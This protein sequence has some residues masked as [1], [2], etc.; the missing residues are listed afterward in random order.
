MRAKVQADWFKP[1]RPEE[2]NFNYTEANAWQYNFFVPQDVNTMIDW[3]GG[4]EPFDEFL[5][6]LFTVSSET[7]GRHQA[8]ITGLIGQ[9]AH[10]NEPS[11]HMAYLYNYAGK[12]WKTQHRVREILHTMYHNQPDGLSGNEDCG[13][14]SSWYVLSAMGFY[15]VTPGSVDYI[16]GAPLFDEVKLNLEN[17]ES[18]VIKA[19]NQS[20]EN[21]YVKSVEMNGKP[22]RKAF[23]K[24]QDMMNGGSLEFTMSENPVKDWYTEFPVQRI[25]E[26]QIVPVP[27][28]KKG[29]N[30]F[31]DKASI[32]LGCADNESEIFYTLGESI[33]KK[34]FKKYTRAIKLE[35]TTTIHFYAQKEDKKSATLKT[36]F[37]QVP[38]NISIKL[39][40]TYAN[41]YAASGDHALIDG[42][43]GG[44]NFKTGTWQ[45]YQGQ[46]VV[47]TIDLSEKQKVN[48]LTVGFLQD[49]KSW[50]VYPEWVEILVSDDGER[51]VSI[52]KITNE[53]SQ[54]KMGAMVQRFAFDV[55]K[56][57]RFIKMIAKN[58][59]VLPEWH[60]GAGGKPWIFTDEMEIE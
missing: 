52:R 1:F 21:Q 51:F 48:K 54:K 6:E 45:G 40:A 26:E 34:S 19:S 57:V 10:G 49:S 29:N 23:I 38:A 18:F 42:L 32:E 2:V 24:H 39:D 25:T 16:L 60:L 14:M 11:H 35:K 8:D 41:Q 56:E 9:Y 33:K 44:D 5:T 36:T 43:K 27:Y 17:G 30:T 37:H 50:I 31:V 46:D 59:G 3:M 20:E 55:D 12:P 7:S 15:P 53:V 13:Q 4:N 58:P 28:V 47:A 22:L